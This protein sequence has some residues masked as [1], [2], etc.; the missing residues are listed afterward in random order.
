MPGLG[1]RHSARRPGFR[2][3][4]AARLPSAARCGNR[5]DPPNQGVPHG[6][7]QKGQVKFQGLALLERAE[8]VVQRDQ[9]TGKSFV[10]Y[11]FSLLVLSLA[12]ENEEFDWSWVNARRDPRLTGEECVRRAP[13]AWREWVHNL[14]FLSLHA[15]TTWTTR[16]WSS[17]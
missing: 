1:D 5:L 12:E 17:P 14:C 7:R 9:T 2:G 4:L 3:T 6:G 16:R 10:N 13:I 15:D 8:R 11:V